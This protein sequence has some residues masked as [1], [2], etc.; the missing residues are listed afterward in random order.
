MEEIASMDVS[1]INSTSSSYW[2]KDL[3]ENGMTNKCYQTWILSILASCVVGLSGVFPLIFVPIESGAKFNQQAKPLPVLPCVYLKFHTVASELKKQK[4]RPAN[5]PYSISWSANG[6]IFLKKKE[7]TSC[8]LSSKE[9]CS[10]GCC[11]LEIICQRW[12]PT[13]DDVAERDKKRGPASG[14]MEN[15]T[16]PPAN[17]SLGP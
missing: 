14:V 12:F 11:V 6:R 16:P 3:L 13:I 17:S 4:F 8:L 2:Y 15:I 7:K 5:I 10:F 1:P 9:V